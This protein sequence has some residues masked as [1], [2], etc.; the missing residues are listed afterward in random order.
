MH[1]AR[2]SGDLREDGKRPYQ[3]ATLACRWRVCSRA[4]VSVLRSPQLRVK[5]AKKMLSVSDMGLLRQP[6]MVEMELASCA[7][8]RCG[9]CLASQ[10]RKNQTIVR[11]VVTFVPSCKFRVGRESAG[12]SKRPCVGLTARER[13]VHFVIGQSH[14]LPGNSRFDGDGLARNFG[15]GK[16]SCLQTLGGCGRPPSFA[17]CLLLCPRR[18]HSFSSTDTMYR[19]ALRSTPRALRAMQ[20]TVASGS[21]RLASTAP[22]SKKGTWKGTGLRWGLAVAAVYFYTTSPIFAAE[23]P[24]TSSQHRTRPASPLTDAT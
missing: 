15:A 22:A 14:G 11:G 4:L 6:D 8:G 3:V 13:W 18:Y 5:R 21:R 7:E 9:V 19:T 16:C 1:I 2:A 23:L 12:D 24:C 10:L 20:P 17:P